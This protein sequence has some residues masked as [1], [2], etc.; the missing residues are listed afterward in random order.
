MG[1]Q[2]WGNTILGPSCTVVHILVHIHILY[3]TGMMLLLVVPV[4]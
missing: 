1:S 4:F 3:Y 2:G